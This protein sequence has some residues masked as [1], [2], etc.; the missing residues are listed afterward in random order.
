[1]IRTRAR[2]HEMNRSVQL[3]IRKWVDMGVGRGVPV[4]GRLLERW[5]LGTCSVPFGIGA[6]IGG[7]VQRWGR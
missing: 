2:G 3:V 5:Q 7:Q 6:G 1:V 4:P